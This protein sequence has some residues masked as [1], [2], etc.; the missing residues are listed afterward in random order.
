MPHT[1]WSGTIASSPAFMV[2]VAL[3]ECADAGREEEEEEEQ[4][5]E[6]EG[7]GKVVR[8]Q[9]RAGVHARRRVVVGEIG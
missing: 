4:E 5:D 3:K 8:K 9:G 2:V 7:R 1:R 6:E